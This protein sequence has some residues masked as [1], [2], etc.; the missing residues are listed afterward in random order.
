MA[1]IKYGSSSL[2]AACG[3]ACCKSKGCSLSPEDMIR[4]IEKKEHTR[5]IRKEVLE[6]FL[7][8]SDFAIDHFSWKTGPFYYLRMRHKCFTF[9]GV[10]AMGECIA[11]TDIGCAREYGSRPKGGRFLEG[12][13]NRQCE[14][15]YT[16]EMM[17]ED[18][19]PY[20]EL[21]AGIFREWQDKME[22]DGTFDR[23]EDAYMEYQME[24]RNR[25]HTSG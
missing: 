13:E 1:E 19:M 23:C 25:Q 15:H 21:L 3:G 14:Q 24:K 16:Q 8:D 12:K 9:I 18:W 10:D 22:A 5:E 20:Q 4:E 17:L 7:P 11:L 6:H 2:C